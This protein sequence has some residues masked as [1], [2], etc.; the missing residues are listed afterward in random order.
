MNRSVN[1]NPSRLLLAVFI[2][3]LLSP[4]SGFSQENRGETRKERK[5]REKAENIT[6]YDQA[7]QLILDSAFVIPADNILFG[8]GSPMNPVQSSINFV[9]MDG[10]EAVIQIGSDFAR[11]SGMNSLGGVTLKGKPANIKVR[12]KEGKQRF[13]MT[14]T[15]TGLIGTASVSITL[16]GSD[17]AVVDVDGMFSGRAFSMRGKVIPVKGANIFEGTEF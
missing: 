14:F 4:F 9:K 13:F 1:Y 5:A 16:T 6:K 7:R 17:R 11:T 10:N 12:E 2:A 15:V 3:M 8:D